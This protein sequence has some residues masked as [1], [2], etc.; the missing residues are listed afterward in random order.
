MSANGLKMLALLMTLLASPEAFALGLRA[1]SNLFS[2][3]FGFFVYLF[4]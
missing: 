4:V 2:I 3:S 1:L